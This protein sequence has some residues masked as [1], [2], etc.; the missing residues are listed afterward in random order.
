METALRRRLSIAPAD[1]DWLPEQLP[2]QWPLI[3]GDIGEWRPAVCTPSPSPSPKRPEPEPTT[4]ALTRAPT[5]PAAAQASGARWATRSPL[6]A[7]PSVGAASMGGCTRAARS[8]RPPRASRRR[9]RRRAA[10]PDRRGTS[11]AA[12]SPRAAAS[13]RAEERPLRGWARQTLTS[14]AADA[15]DHPRVSHRH[16]GSHGRDGLLWSALVSSMAVAP[17]DHALCARGVC[18]ATCIAVS[19]C[20]CCT[21]ALPQCRRCAV[22]LACARDV[23]ACACACDSVCERAMLEGRRLMGAHA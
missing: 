16:A 6:R 20:L 22:R 21:P 15:P 17:C 10:R 5:P 23:C 2:A 12:A 7:A 14:S 19:I 4:Q 8:A 11:Q 1:A 18:M 9:W 13:R 3:P